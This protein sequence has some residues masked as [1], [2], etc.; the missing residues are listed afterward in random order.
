MALS[1]AFFYRA[2][3]AS[4]YTFLMLLLLVVLMVSPGDIVNQSRLRHNVYPILIVSICYL[5]AVLIAGVIYFG[6][7]YIKRSVLNSIPRP[8]IPIEKGDVNARVRKMIVA[9]LGRSAA[10]AFAAQP[11]ALPPFHGHEVPRDSVDG[12][13]GD[14][15]TNL[16]TVDTKGEP[17]QQQHHGK[18]F[19][20]KKVATVEEKMGINLPP[21]QAVWGTIE[22]PGWAPPEAADSLANLQ[23]STVVAELPNLL[24]AK[25]LTLA[26]P[27][28]PGSMPAQLSGDQA[29][30]PVD[31]E[32]VA[33]LQRS[34]CM[35]LRDYLSH[36][37]ELGVIDVANDVGNANHHDGDNDD[38][39]GRPLSAV[40]NSFLATYEYARFSAHM[41]TEGDFR[42]LMHD[43]ATL[44][45]RMTP[46]DPTRLFDDAGDEDHYENGSMHSL[47]DSP[48]EPSTE[49]ID[50]NAARSTPTT[51]HSISR[52]NSSIHQS[53][54]HSMHQ[55][56]G[57]FQAALAAAGLMRSNSAA[58]ASSR[59]S[60]NSGTSSFSRMSGSS[61]ETSRRRRP[62]RSRP[63]PPPPPPLPSQMPPPPHFDRTASLPMAKNRHR[64]AGGAL[65]DSSSASTRSSSAN[66]IVQV[67]RPF[68]TSQPSCSS[69]RS[70][71]STTGSVIRL[72]ERGDTTGLPYRLIQTTSHGA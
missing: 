9:G 57:G 20:L 56:P 10:V 5:S 70:T 2:V 66:S 15:G 36:L 40:V 1:L 52:S 34:P 60:G 31:P 62:F 53:M 27:P 13:G 26:P 35:G 46:L 58:T 4:S 17:H 7:L 38:A 51:P 41:L 43:L 25:A 6:R 67:R 3:Y 68:P 45:R 71:A 16:G 69:L 23:Y 32:A 59:I 11:R 72:A 24:E 50:N 64:G 28:L 65:P 14:L 22:H 8:W 47:Y 54:H 30:F 37:A 19:R 63:P 48:S 12:D 33:L 39:D 49:D 44:L 18:L 42:Q 29:P 55:R 21:F 61:N